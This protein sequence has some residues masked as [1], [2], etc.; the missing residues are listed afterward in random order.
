MNTEIGHFH[1][2]LYGINLRNLKNIK[3]S[4]T[5]KKKSYQRI[6][7]STTNDNLIIHDTKLF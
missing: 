5:N 7:N 4:I 6:Y 2:D 1:N 3:F